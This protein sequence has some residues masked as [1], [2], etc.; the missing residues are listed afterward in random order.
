MAVEVTVKIY[1]FGFADGFNK[2]IV[3]KKEN[4]YEDNKIGW[5]EG[6]QEC[7]LS[8]DVLVQPSTFPEGF[9]MTCVVS[10]ALGKPLVVTNIPGPSELVVDGKAGFIVPSNNPQKLSERILQILNNRELA[11][12]LGIN[13]R[14]HV[15]M[16]YDIKNTM[17]QIENIYSTI[18]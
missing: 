8:F 13:G 5:R 12:L 11:C 7:I 6:I 14:E 18:I 17:K 10:M 15:R 9:G 3:L 4:S 1:I 16:K 2:K